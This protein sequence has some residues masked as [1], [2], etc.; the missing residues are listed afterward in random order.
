MSYIIPKTWLILQHFS[1]HKQRTFTELESFG[2]NPKTLSKYLKILLEN[3]LLK[4]QGQAYRLTGQGSL[5]LQLLSQLEHLISFP[6]ILEKIPRREIHPF[7]HA[8]V[9]QLQMYYSER[10]KGIVLYGSSGSTDWRP[11]SD[12]DLFVIVKDWGIPTWER[13]VELYR[14]RLTTLNLLE[15]VIDI[16]VSYYPLDVTEVDRHHA[17]YPDIQRNGVILYQK[18][19]FIESLF[20][21]I[22]EDLK[23][24]EKIHITTP[25]G[26]SLWVAQKIIQKNT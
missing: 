23:Q 1:P 6:K 4:K 11:D 25:N 16:P 24:E 14:I 26:E 21:T 9:I 12:I 7:L 3:N 17:I 15:E 13:A 8:H 2:F 19:D 20:E 22:R 5:Y 18:K 10:L